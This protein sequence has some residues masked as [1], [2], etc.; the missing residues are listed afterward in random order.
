MFWIANDWQNTSSSSVR[1]SNTFNKNINKYSIISAKWGQQLAISWLLYT[2]LQNKTLSWLLCTNL[3]NKT[4]C[5]RAT[6]FARS[7]K[8]QRKYIVLN[9]SWKLSP[10]ISG[11][12]GQNI[13]LASLHEL[14]KQNTLQTGHYFREIPKKSA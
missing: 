13:V 2:N 6:T 10:I 5:K 12:R 11:G 7:Q 3:Q 8:S 14:A 9:S 4:H 1:W